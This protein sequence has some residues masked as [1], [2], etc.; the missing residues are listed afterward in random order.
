M[1]NFGSVYLVGRYGVFSV[2]EDGVEDIDRTSVG[3]GWTVFENCEIRLEHQ[4][5]S[6][7]NEDLTFMQLVV[8]F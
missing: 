8:G 7:S 3:G 5:N 2:D 4:I 6:E 1:Y